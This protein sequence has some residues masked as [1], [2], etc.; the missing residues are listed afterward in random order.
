MGEPGSSFE[1]EILRATACCVDLLAAMRGYHVEIGSGDDGAQSTYPLKIHVGVGVGTLHRVHLGD[2]TLEKP[3]GETGQRLHLPR[4][5]FFVAGHAVVN[6]GEMEGMA[7]SGEMAIAP[8]ARPALYD[9]LNLVAPPGDGPIIISE[10]DDLET[11]S[12]ILQAAC[13]VLNQRWGNDGLGSEGVLSKKPQVM[14]CNFLK[15][16]TYVDESLAFHLSNA[17]NAAQHTG[18]ANV[19]GNVGTANANDS[20]DTGGVNQLRNVSIV[21]VRFSELSVANLN[22]SST[23]NLAQRIFIMIIGVLKRFNGCLRQF[24]CD[25]KAASALIVFGLFGF[26]HERGEEL[27]A[28]RAAW[29]IRCKLKP[30][31]G[32]SFGIGVTSGVV[33]YGLVGNEHRADG[34]CLGA[35]VNLA[36]RFMTHELSAGRL[37]CDQTIRDKCYASFEFENLGNLHFKGFPPLAVF[38]PNS[39]SKE[40]D[41]GVIELGDIF[42]RDAE[43]ELLSSAVDGWD[44]GSSV[45]LAILGHSGAGKSTIS[46]WLKVYMRSRFGDRLIFG[47]T[48]FLELVF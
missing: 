16:L 21:F 26:A 40:V 48:V 45:R 29:E 23:L 42:G 28:L 35:T 15:V 27:V 6:A 5:E 13:V 46:N 37:L 33:L 44:R 7:E 17:S 24:A 14:S 2:P 22:E 18:Y 11:I 20:L 30:L 10:K 12:G 39:R 8:A 1:F 25:D 38:A 34:T 43:M 31:V 9:I 3:A 19:E 36:A 4:R 32:A 41:D 47:Y